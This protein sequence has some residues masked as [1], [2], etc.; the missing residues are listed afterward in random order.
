MEVGPFAA[1]ELLKDAPSAPAVGSFLLTTSGP[2]WIVGLE[3]RGHL[4]PLTL[5]LS[6]ERA[7]TYPGLSPAPRNGLRIANRSREITLGEIVG[8]ADPSP[9]DLGIDEHGQMA[10]AVRL[11]HGGESTDLMMSLESGT[12]DSESDLYR[13]LWVRRWRLDLASPG[14]D[15]KVTLVDRFQRS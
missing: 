15:R 6:G 12:L 3:E 8:N 13:F 2:V 11:I 1:G 10:V 7:F 14:G 9:G 4:K 5:P